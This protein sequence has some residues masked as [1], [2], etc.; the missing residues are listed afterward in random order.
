MDDQ[1]KD[2]S[3]VEAVSDVSTTDVITDLKTGI[4]NL[5]V[6]LFHQYVPMHGPE[7]AVIMSTDFLQEIIV[8]FRQTLVDEE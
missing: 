4:Y 3:L 5:F 8:N 2:P 7:G 6:N 1:T